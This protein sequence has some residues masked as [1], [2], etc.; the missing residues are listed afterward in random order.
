MLKWYSDVKVK[1]PLSLLVKENERGHQTSD[2]MLKK[3]KGADR[4]K[5]QPV[6][7]NL[8]SL[9]SIES[10]EELL[11]ISKQ[12]LEKTSIVMFMF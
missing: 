7:K 3:V 12:R 6:L 11:D 10:E 2:S 5:Y 8:K 9:T 1:W 4:T